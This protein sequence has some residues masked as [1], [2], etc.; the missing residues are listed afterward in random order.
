ML[1]FSF[2]I[3]CILYFIHDYVLGTYLYIFHQGEY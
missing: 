3:F 2:K 1:S